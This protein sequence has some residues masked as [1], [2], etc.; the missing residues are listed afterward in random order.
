MHF[1]SLARHRRALLFN[2]FPAR[3]PTL[4]LPPA[5]RRVVN[6]FSFTIS[7]WHVVKALAAASSNWHCRR[8]TLCR[9]GCCVCLGSRRKINL[10]GWLLHVSASRGKKWLFFRPLALAADYVCAKTPKFGPETNAED[11]CHCARPGKSLYFK[12]LK[13]LGHK[14]MS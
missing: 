3:R 12:K 9:A 10:A 4:L 11:G 14:I 13:L 8:G 5:A 2:P 7:T 1:L 6:R